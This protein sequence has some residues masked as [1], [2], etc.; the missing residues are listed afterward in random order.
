MRKA[1]V[2]LTLAMLVAGAT[3]NAAMA[4]SS[5]VQ[6]IPTSYLSLYK[7]WGATAG[8]PWSLLAAVGSVESGH[9]SNPGA[10]VP[11]D[12]GV[13]GPMQFQAGSNKLAKKQDSQGDQGFGGT[14]GIWRTASGHPPYR[15][16]DPDDEIAAAAAKLRYDAGPTL[17]WAKALYQ[18]NALGAYVSLVLKREKQYR[19][20]TCATAGT[21]TI[22][23]PSTDTTETTTAPTTTAP[24]TTA[25]TTTAPTT[26][27]PTTTTTVP[28]A[29]IAS[30]LDSSSVELSS[31]AAAD[32]NAG[33]VDSR[34]VALLQWISRR[35]SIAI[36][37]FRTGHPKFVAGTKRVSNNWYGRGTTITWVD[38][39]AV[40]PGSVAARALWQQLRTAPAAIRPSELGAP[41]ADPANPRYYSGSDAMNLIHIGFDGPTQH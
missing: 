2:I 8:V 41:W 6:T 34:L 32:L 39:K 33:I 13:L 3:G 27:A 37:E 20:G 1:L 7:Q 40:S 19:L 30:L 9:G 16:D 35:H 15:M 25:P 22:A 38:G 10:L 21:S 11:H 5:S 24:T 4:C 36:S 18:Y 26:T 28:G 14:W 12:R 31:S 23:A 29:S 17:N